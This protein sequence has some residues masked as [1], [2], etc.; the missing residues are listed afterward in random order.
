MMGLFDAIAK[1]SIDSGDFCGRRLLICSRMAMANQLLPVMQ[2]ELA[3][4]FSLQ[5]K[6][7]RIDRSLSSDIRSGV[8]RLQI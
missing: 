3:K 7:T 1:S 2:L 5:R 6:S 8:L 4:H